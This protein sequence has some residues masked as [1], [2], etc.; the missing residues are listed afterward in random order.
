[1]EFLVAGFEI[2]EQEPGIEGI[3]KAAELPGRICYGS[4]DK[5]TEGSAEKFCK[6]LM[7]SNH[8]AP[9]EHATIYLK[10]DKETIFARVKN[11]NTRPLLN[12]ENLSNTIER[13]LS[14]REYLYEQCKITVDTTNKTPN[15]IVNEIIEKIS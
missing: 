3:Y 2:I 8:G 13:I 1:M 11:D 9:L 10:A 12:T 15:E 4:Q 6:G 5:I 7:D 14:E